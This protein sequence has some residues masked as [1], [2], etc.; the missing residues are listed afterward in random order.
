MMMHQRV[1]IFFKTN[2]DSDSHSDDSA[3]ESSEPQ[4]LFTQLRFASPSN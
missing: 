4:A 2:D 1:T 3:S